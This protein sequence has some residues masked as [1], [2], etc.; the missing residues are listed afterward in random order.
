MKKIG[1]LAVHNH[2]YGSILQ[3][4]AL[5]RFLEDKGYS[6]EILL[7][8][9]TNYVK[10]A[11]RLF[12]LPLLKATVKMKYKSIYA[13]TFQKETFEKVL[14]SREQAFVDFIDAN[15]KFSKVY[16][17]R[18]NLINGT[19]NYDAF[20]LGSD[21]VWNPMNL[22][23]DY[24]TMTFI[25]D[26]KKKITYAP[27]FG[28]SVIPDYQ[29]KKTADYL[30]RIDC[31]SVR[32]L[33]GQKIV[34]QLTGRN[35]QVVVDPTMLVDK[36]RWD[37][38][39]GERIVKEPYIMCYFISTNPDHR[40]FAK[41]L[42]KKTGL[43]IVTIPHVDEFVKAD[44]NFGD[45]VPSGIGPAQFINLISNAEYVCTDSFHATV[46]SVLYERNFFT[47]NRFAQQT[48]ASTNSRLTSILKILGLED[49]H[50]DSKREVTDRDLQNI[51]FVNAHAKLK[52][53][54]KK[55]EEYLINS[56]EK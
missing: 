38:L 50:T 14:C 29:R 27:S 40:V 33:S 41:R 35:A 2:N 15:V 19:K 25:P 45:I 44:V 32:E 52:E 6:T 30:R 56:L 5:Q 31:I 20:V 13:K 43:K 10:Q 39:R 22:G 28:V 26:N 47:F 7:Y 17:G 4:Y 36:S 11:M 16:K 21:Q 34:K 8:K 1:I 49:R 24:F 12:N 53:M 51:D 37:Q 3:T 23:G 18:Q 42:A 9:K 48:S 55:S 46:F 54:Q